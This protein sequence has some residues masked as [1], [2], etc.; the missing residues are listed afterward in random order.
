LIFLDQSLA[1]G[2]EGEEEMGAA[3]ASL[4]DLFVDEVS[5][6]QFT[7]EILQA[8]AANTPLLR[9]MKRAGADAGGFVELLQDPRVEVVQPITELAKQQAIQSLVSR[10]AEISSPHREEGSSGDSGLTHGCTSFSAA[11]A[12]AFQIWTLRSSG[13]LTG[14]PRMRMMITPMRKHRTRA[15]KNWRKKLSSV[16]S[17]SGRRRWRRESMGTV[18]G[19]FEIIY[20]L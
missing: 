20:D 16:L 12:S 4:F 9:L 6:A 2:R 5:P 18:G 8:I 1:F 13:P 7:E 19:S 11:A 10:R 15:P 17:G 14:I 3:L